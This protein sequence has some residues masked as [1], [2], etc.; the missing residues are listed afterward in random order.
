MFADYPVQEV[1]PEV[2]KEAAPAE[3]VYEKDDF[4]DK[5]SCDTLERLN[6]GGH[7]GGGPGRAPPRARFAEQRK[8]DIE[9]F[10]GTGIA[11]RNNYGRGRGRRG[12][13]VR[14]C[15]VLLAA[16]FRASGTGYHAHFVLDV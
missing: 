12:R 3:K 5:L 9:T 10:G 16:C 14:C 8:L 11:R 4:F 2:E 6:V 15:S 1:K 13:G 7:G